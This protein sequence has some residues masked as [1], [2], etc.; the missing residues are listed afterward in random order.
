MQKN[1]R[2]VAQSTLLLSAFGFPLR[3]E[4]GVNRAYPPILLYCVMFPSV[5]TCNHG[6]PHFCRRA[7]ITDVLRQARICVCGLYAVRMM[8][9]IFP[10]YVL[11]THILPYDLCWRNVDHARMN[12]ASVAKQDSND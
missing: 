7:I 1:T 2:L 11:N 4:C 5:R 12:N 8:Y 6:N 9:E 10:Y 3:Y